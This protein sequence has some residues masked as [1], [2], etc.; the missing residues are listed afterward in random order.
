LGFDL[1]GETVGIVGTGRIGAITAKILHGFGCRLLGYDVSQNPDCVALG[2]EYVALAELFAA[3]DL[4]SL[5]CPLIP[6]TD[7][8]IG[9]EA[10]R[11]NE[12]GDHVDQHQSQSVD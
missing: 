9:A 11:A 12:T 7:H 2:M 5:H 3:S 8:L 6:E 4:V 1:D 10:Q